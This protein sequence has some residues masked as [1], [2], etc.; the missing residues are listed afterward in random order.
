MIEAVF[1][2]D[3]HLHP[4][5]QAIQERFNQFIEWA[6]VSV[7]NVYILGDFFHAW[8]GDD[9]VDEWS[10]VIARQLYSLKIQGINLFY[11]HG[12]R[13]FLLG[14]AFAHMA[15]WTILSEPTV[16]QL[17]QEKILLVH[18]DRYC[19]KDRAHQRFRFLTRNRIFSTLFLSLPLKYRNR[20]VNQVRYR[21]QMNQSKSIEEMDVV[22]E[23]VI[24]HMLYYQVS[25][26]I[27]GHT[28]KFG[29]TT[30]QKNSQKLKRYVLSDWDDKPQLLC[31]DN[32][33]G[34]Y[35]AHL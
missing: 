29:M 11:M 30:H 17:G 27:H 1:I 22:A 31:Y 5:D 28:H 13:D 33:K 2:S 24:D 3:L 18:G 25:Q 26:L 35:F 19:T 8:A 23:V 12:N 34:L 10:T 4:D 14:K 20:L 16:I 9:T 15:G 7:K 32:T 21:S 6:R